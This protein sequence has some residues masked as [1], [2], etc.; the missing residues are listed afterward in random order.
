MQFAHLYIAVYLLLALVSADAK[1]YLP[2]D[3]VGS[4]PVI[5]NDADDDK[6]T[7]E[8]EQEAIKIG[9]RFIRRLQQANDLAPMINEMFVDDYAERLQQQAVNHSLLFLAAPVAQQASRDEL[10]RYYLALNNCGY[11]GGLL[12]AAY[13]ASHPG[14][15][16]EDELQI[17]Q[18][19]PP[20]ILA[21]FKGDPVLAALI[22]S[23]KGS[24]SQANRD[25]EKTG[26]QV[27]ESEA[28]DKNA[29]VKSIEALRTFTTTLEQLAVLARKHLAALP[30][31]PIML[32]RHQ[33]ED[34]ET[35]W[36]S[37]R[38]WMN[39]RLAILRAGFYG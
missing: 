5:A 11:L 18:M 23:E 35:N 39:P 16:D 17:E 30:T 19:L 14:R 24:E 33:G 9:E 36:A 38:E 3:K 34:E 31:P 15:D 22:E 12:F 25:T 2:K 28:D 8:E 32:E 4:Q 21:L 6:I 37:E 26:R 27:A 10:R 13:E 29:W 7:P 20:D 1:S